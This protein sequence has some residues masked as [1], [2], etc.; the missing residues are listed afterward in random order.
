MEMHPDWPV[1]QDFFNHP[2]PRLKSRKPIWSDTTP[3]DVASKW[4]EI[5]QSNS[6]TNKNLISD[7]TVRLP[8][9]NLQRST[10]STLNCFH[11]GQGSCAA[12]LHKWHMTPT[13]RCQCGDVQM[14][15]HIVKSCPLTRFADVTCFGSI[16]LMMAQ[17]RGCKM[18]QRR[19]SRNENDPIT[20]EGTRCISN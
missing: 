13:D 4:K 2:P 9:F 12:N 20:S 11:T 18:L 8:G 5:W 7:L 15:I 19:H 16:L 14:M 1:H 17:S 3:V 6:V 10:W